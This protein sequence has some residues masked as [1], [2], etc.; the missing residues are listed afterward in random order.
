MTPQQ[1]H[2]YLV[3]IPNQPRDGK[4]RPA[5][6]VSINS[7]NRMASHV[8]AVPVTST[9][10]PGPFNVAL[11]RGDG[12]LQND[13]TAQCDQVTTLDKTLL[14]QGPFSKVIPSAKLSE[15][16]DKISLAIGYTKP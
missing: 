4:S 6:V 13:S 8:I 10:R 16:L 5:V 3:K 12:G 7:I 14:L 11:K 1:G 15:I 9:D 2:I